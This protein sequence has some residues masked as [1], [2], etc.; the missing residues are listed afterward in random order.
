L[1]SLKLHGGA[2][3]TPLLD[4]Q[5]NLENRW[6]HPGVSGKRLVY[7]GENVNW[8][9]QLER[10]GQYYKGDIVR[11]DMERGATKAEV[12]GDL[13]PVKLSEGEGM[14]YRTAFLYDP[15]LNTLV[16]QAT[17]RGIT[18]SRFAFFFNVFSDASQD[19]ELLPYMRQDGMDRLNRLE[20]A[21][22]FSVKIGNT[23][24][25]ASLQNTG[26]SAK[27]KIEGLAEH[28]EAPK[29]EI[30]FTCGRQWRSENLDLD[31]IRNSIA[32]FITPDGEIE[33]EEIRINGRGPDDQSE[34]IRLVEEHFRDE[35]SV[36]PGNFRILPYQARVQNL[37]ASYR[38]NQGAIRELR[39]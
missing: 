30:R 9:Y 13:E 14:G 16:L 2:C 27:Q 29:M 18:P 34:K 31:A 6:G 19:I 5:V 17:R 39:S 11:V 28:V 26:H 20:K 4:G 15:Q 7:D 25:A 38:R 22:V 8:A 23:G 37:E 1:E 32:E 33:A 35:M 10:D 24:T 21:H 36:E 3:P 12:L